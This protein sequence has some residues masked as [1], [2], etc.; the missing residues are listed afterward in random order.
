MHGTRVVILTH[1]HCILHKFVFIIFEGVTAKKT[2]QN[3]YRR[4]VTAQ[5][6]SDQFRLCE[7]IT[8]SRR[9]IRVFSGAGCKRSWQT[10]I[11]QTCG[12][13]I[14][15]KDHLPTVIWRKGENFVDKMFEFVQKCHSTQLKQ[16]VLKAMNLLKQQH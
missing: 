8:E 12:V 16:Q 14:D 2:T 1:V 3:F 5:L 9:L 10:K 7:T 11:S 4:E 15:E 13:V 6:N